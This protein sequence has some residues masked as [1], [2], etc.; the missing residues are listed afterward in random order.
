LLECFS[1]RPIDFRVSLTILTL[2]ITF[3]RLRYTVL[4]RINAAL[5][6]IR[7]IQRILWYSLSNT[8]TIMNNKLDA[9]LLMGRLCLLL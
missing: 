2:C 6:H 5:T 4:I 7:T 1:G 3:R 8:Y 9:V